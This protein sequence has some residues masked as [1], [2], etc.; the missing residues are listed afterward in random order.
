MLIARRDYPALDGLW[1]RTTLTSLAVMG[2][3]ACA[4]WG[5]VYALNVLESPLAE[6][7]LEPGITGLLLLAAMLMQVSQ[8][9]TAYMRA[10]KQEPIVVLS[11]ASSL[12]IGLSVWLLG[13]RWGPTGAVS[14]YLGV[15]IALVVWETA[16]WRRFRA[17]VTAAPAE[18]PV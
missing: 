15:M 1:L 2:A 11:V 8:C 14:A 13:R 10:H 12:A 18:Q 4:V 5:L 3:G 17:D 7:V 6:R 9:E 16:I